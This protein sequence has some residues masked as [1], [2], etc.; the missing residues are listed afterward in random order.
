MI[1]NLGMYQ[2]G[3]TLKEHVSKEM[4]VKIKEILK[5]NGHA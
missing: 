1:M 2:D 3:T 5:K 4:Y